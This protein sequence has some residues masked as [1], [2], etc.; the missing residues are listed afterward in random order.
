MSLDERAQQQVIEL[1]ARVA[2]E[3]VANA[4]RGDGGLRLPFATTRPGTLTGTSVPGGTAMVLVDGDDE[5][6]PCTNITG[7]YIAGNGAVRVVVLFAPPQ[8]AYIVGSMVDES[9]WGTTI[10]QGHEVTAP[11]NNLTVP[12]SDYDFDH[13]LV[14]ITSRNTSATDGFARLRINGHSGGTD[15]RRSYM[16][17]IA[18]GVSGGDA[19][20][21][22]IELA[23]SP[24]TATIATHW[25]VGT[26]ELHSYWSNVRRTHFLGRWYGR[27]GG[28]R[29]LVEYGG[30]TNFTNQEPVSSL[31]FY[32]DQGNFA[33]GTR[34]TVA[35]I[36]RRGL[37]NGVV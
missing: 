15:Y 13:L 12:I 27:S 34:I 2:R 5:P 10:L 37:R 32:T 17:S 3:A 25:G 14:Q 9:T 21:T 30:T 16:A 28:T 31:L 22:N 24:G 23:Y 35:G 29:V 6:I 33:V 18:G 7:R 11:V 26:V 19:D 4:I 1:A 20:E 8:A 36:G